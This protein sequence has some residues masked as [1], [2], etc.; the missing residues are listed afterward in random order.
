M[1]DDNI[2]SAFMVIDFVLTSRITNVFS[3]LMMKIKTSFSISKTL[4]S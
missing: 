4:E 3:Y 1:V 2:R